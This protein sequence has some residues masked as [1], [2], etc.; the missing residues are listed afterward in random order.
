MSIFQDIYSRILQFRNSSQQITGIVTT[1]SSSGL[2]SNLVTERGIAS[3]INALIPSGTIWETARRTAPTGWLLLADGASVSRSTYAAL[4]DAIV[5]SL[6]TFTV[7][8]ATPGV[9]SLTAHGFIAGDAFYV[10]TTGALPTG[11]TA[12]TLYYVIA[13]GLATDSFQFSATSGGSAVNTY[14]S[15][16]GTHT[17]RACPYGLGDGSTTFNLPKHAGR[18]GVGQGAA[19]GL[20]TRNLGATGGEEAHALVEAEGPIHAH[21]QR[22]WDNRLAYA[23]SGSSPRLANNPDTA[24]TGTPNKTASSGSGTAHN[25]MQPY[26]VVNY[27]IK[28]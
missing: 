9:I 21:Q 28:I 12:N 24:T 16:S 17:L 19:S 7:T 6:G 18:V 25:T 23:G 4:F 27:M 22:T 1:V 26:I 20:T 15:Q 14:G 13:A 3:A 11:M 5:P 2:D 8:I 10:T